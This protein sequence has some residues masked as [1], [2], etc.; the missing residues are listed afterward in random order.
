MMVSSRDISPRWKPNANVQSPILQ[1]E[2]SLEPVTEEAKLSGSH[3]AAGSPP[4]LDPSE[5]EREAVHGDLARHSGA[6]E[7]AIPRR[8]PSPPPESNTL[9]EDEEGGEENEEEDE[10][11]DEVRAPLKTLPPP[12]APV[13]RTHM[14]GPVASRR[15]QAAVLGFDQGRYER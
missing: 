6:A 4:P 11:V 15:R 7:H 12:L 10:V 8:I 2:P 9:P 1:D 3:R 14:D 13:V 5:S